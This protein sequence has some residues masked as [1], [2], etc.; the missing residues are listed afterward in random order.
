MFDFK[1]DYAWGAE[2]AVCMLDLPDDIRRIVFTFVFDPTHPGCADLLLLSK[3]FKGRPVQKFSCGHAHCAFNLE[4]GRL[5]T[6]GANSFGQCGLGAAL[7]NVDVPV[8]VKKNVKL[9]ECG[10]VFTLCVS[11]GSTYFTGAY[12]RDPVTNNVDVYLGIIDGFVKTLYHAP[13]FGIR[14]HMSGTALFD[15]GYST[16]V[17]PFLNRDCF[18]DGPESPNSVMFTDLHVKHTELCGFGRCMEVNDFGRLIVSTN[19]DIHFVDNVVGKIY[20]DEKIVV[21]RARRRVAIIQ[22]EYSGPGTSQSR[23]EELP[24]DVVDVT[25]WRGKLYVSTP[26]QQVG[27]SLRGHKQGCAACFRVRFPHLREYNACC[28]LHRECAALCFIKSGVCPCGSAL[29][30]SKWK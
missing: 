27:C 1:T 24:D 4:D 26:R 28:L 3:T 10:P 19:D 20:A 15:Y 23:V 9:V 7:R 30:T 22:Y 21:T 12:H 13:Q 8:L 25:M 16:M 11:D 6:F 29:D 2:M 18:A 5:F 17:V 14:C